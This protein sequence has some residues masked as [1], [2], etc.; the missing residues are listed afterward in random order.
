MTAQV[1]FPMVSRT[2]ALIMPLAALDYAKHQLPPSE[3]HSATKG[4]KL[5]PTKVF[6]LNDNDKPEVVEVTLGIKNRVSA[7]VVSG[8]SEGDEVITG[9]IEVGPQSRPRVMIH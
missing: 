2:N 8:L 1:Y 5:R 4:K 9:P 7:E 6:I 3:V